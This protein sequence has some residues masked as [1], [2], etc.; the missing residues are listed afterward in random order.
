MLHTDNTTDAAVNEKGSN[1]AAAARSQFASDD[2]ML[3]TI[4]STRK[5][6]RIPAAGK[7][8]CSVNDDT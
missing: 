3:A 1:G 7:H 5:L 4:F 6:P 8:S 2:P